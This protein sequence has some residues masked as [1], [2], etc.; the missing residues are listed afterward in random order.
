MSYIKQ[1]EEL[2]ALV[3]KFDAGLLKSDNTEVLPLS[4]FSQSY[5][6]LKE[7]MS[8]LHEMEENQVLKMKKQLDIHEVMI[9]EWVPDKM[10]QIVSTPKVETVPEEAKPKEVKPEEVSVVEAPVVEEAKPALKTFKIALND[11][12]LFQ[13]TLF[14]GNGN[15]L[16]DVLHALSTQPSVEEAIAYLDSRFAWNWAD[17]SPSL[18]KALL[19]KTYA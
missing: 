12:F 4:F 14:S 13:R 6:L 7:M 16:D 2:S 17:E 15:E 9:S 10:S 8:R 3:R 19:E 11:R 1:L 5:D 18:F